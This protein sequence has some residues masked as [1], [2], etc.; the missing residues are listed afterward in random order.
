MIGRTI[1]HYK[2]LEKLGEGGMGVV[3]KAE[4][5][6]LHRPVV[7][8]FLSHPHLGESAARTR[9]AQE[10]QA[11]AILNH[12]NIATIYEYDEVEDPAVGEKTSFIAMEYVEGE[13]LKDKI[14]RGPLSISETVNILAQIVGG[15]QTAHQHGII[16]RDI[17]PA[18]IMI[19]GDGTA[20]ILDFGLAKLGDRTNIT[21]TSTIVGTIAYM[22]PEQISGEAVDE[23][24]DIWSLGVV[25]FEMLTQQLPFRGEYPPAIMYSIL[26][27]VPPD[28]SQLRKDIPVDLQA[29]CGRFLQK[30][31]Q[32]RP[33]STAEILEEITSGASRKH[34]PFASWRRYVRQKRFVVILSG[35]V[36]LCISA[37]L[38]IPGLLVHK[39]P[40]DSKWRLGVLQFE[41]RTN[42]KALS[43]W[44][45]LIQTLLVREL[46]GVEGLG[47]V[48]PM[49]LNSLL[50]SSMG[51]SLPPREA[52]LS[53]VI[54]IAKLTMIIDGTITSTPRGFSIHSTVV[55]YPSREVAFSPHVEIERE[56]DLPAAVENLSGQVLDF[57][58]VKML[59]G[60]KDE[61]LRPW[62]ANRTQN[63]GAIRA[64]MQASDC[65]FR[66]T[67]GMAKYILRAIEL[68]ST[69]ISPRIWAITG[70]VQIGHMDEAEQ[71]LKFLQR[72]EPTAS[73][74]D[75]SMI[76]WA[77][78]YIDGDVSAQARYLQAALEY[79][80]GNNIILYNLA[81]D[82]FI[83]QDYEGAI[84][85]LTPTVEMKWHYSPAYTLLGSCYDRM[86]QF[87]RAREILEQ[88][89]S[90]K[91]VD[92]DIYGL[93]ST[94]AYRDGDT[95]KAL[96]YEDLF[97]QRSREG[98]DSL[99][100][101]YVTLAGANLD[102]GFHANAIRLYRLAISLQPAIAQYHDFLAQALLESR[103]LDTARSECLLALRLDST[104]AN[105]YNT[106]AHIYEVQGDTQ[107][108]LL[109]YQSFL[110]KD[111]TSSTAEIVRRRIAALQR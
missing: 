26:N 107:K 61:D 57:L 10:A 93:L 15:L 11:S 75:Q 21:Q 13:T 56:A 77:A 39:G 30:D 69:F 85:S 53:N 43:E 109:Q 74:F 40:A 66:G 98:S 45:K 59:H 103:I 60:S 82:R 51:S 35:L 16:H 80:P 14:S 4:D 86:K 25:L 9:F 106:L 79:S 3:Y 24:S 23:R 19:T 55:E 101:A 22:S 102:E 41:N 68:D 95:A 72:L 44:S 108:A 54:A 47:V 67:P 31:R 48:D 96:S 5:T 100:S 20:K 18:N 73:P 42:E 65:I 50:E 97:M 17:K 94:L 89:L 2:I 38:I 33:Q 7:L 49:S 1:S 76:G 71:H 105:A 36:V 83:L 99:W 64:F 58:Q 37:W 92:R 8:K 32:M 6:K 62:L 28:I 91:P 70:L 87:N 84:N 88:S 12:P 29:L 52:D 111:T 34:P 46:T 90:I 63:M 78:A 27:E 81:L 104:C 110:K